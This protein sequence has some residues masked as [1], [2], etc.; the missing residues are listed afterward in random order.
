MVDYQVYSKFHGDSEA[1][2]FSAK[3]QVPYDQ[4]PDAIPNT[5]TLT[6]AHKMLLPPGIHGFFLKEKKWS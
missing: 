1:F 6:E 3:P 5:A 4:W 2:K